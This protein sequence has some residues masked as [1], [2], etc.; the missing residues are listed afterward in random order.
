M[1]HSQG[2]GLGYH[3]IYKRVKMAVEHCPRCGGQMRGNGSMVLPYRCDCGEWQY[4][5]SLS[6]YTIKSLSG[7]VIK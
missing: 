5:Y 2:N 3:P 6:A 1:A 7:E 4:D